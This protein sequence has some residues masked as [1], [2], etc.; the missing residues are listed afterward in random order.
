M[1]CVD[2]SVVGQHTVSGTDRIY[3]KCIFGS[4]NGKNDEPNVRVDD[5]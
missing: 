4:R 1:V 5:V 3:P 2:G